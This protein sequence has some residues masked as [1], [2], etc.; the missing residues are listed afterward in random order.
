VTMSLEEAEVKSP[1]STRW[2]DVVWMEEQWRLFSGNVFR[3]WV[4]GGMR[5]LVSWALFRAPSLCL[6]DSDCGNGSSSR[7]TQKPTV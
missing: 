2:Q 7:L 5:Y 6:R 3:P 4:L 1:L